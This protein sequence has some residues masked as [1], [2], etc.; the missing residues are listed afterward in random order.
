[1]V[2]QACG[3]A[4]STDLCM[5]MMGQMA[6]IVTLQLVSPTTGVRA[7]VCCRGSADAASTHSFGTRSSSRCSSVIGA[8]SGTIFGWCPSTFAVMPRCQSVGLALPVGS[9][10]ASCCFTD[11][12]ELCFITFKGTV[13]PRARSMVT[14]MSSSTGGCGGAAGAGAGAGAACGSGAFGAAAGACPPG[15]PRR[16]PME[17]NSLRAP[18]GSSPDKDVKLLPA[19]FTS[20][21]S[22]SFASPSAAMTALRTSSTVQSLMTSTVTSLAIS[23]TACFTVTLTRLAAGLGGACGLGGSAFGCGWG[24]AWWCAWGGG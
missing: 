17:R 11:Q 5:P 8:S 10:S 22:L 2:W 24:A 14:V 6:R 1:M 12:T 3:V 9:M 13:K 23:A 7:V 19:F 18:S 21:T 16:L 20:L 15:A 4:A